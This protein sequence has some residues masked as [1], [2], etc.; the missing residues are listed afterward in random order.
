MEEQLRGFWIHTQK[1]CALFSLSPQLRGHTKLPERLEDEVILNIQ[2]ERK[3]ID[4]G[5][6]FCH[7]CSVA[8]S[9]PTLCDPQTA[10]CQA[11]LSFTI[12]WS[13]LRLLK[14]MS[15]ELMMASNHLILCHHLLL[16]P[17]IF[18]RIRVFFNEL[19]LCIRW[20][21]YWSFGFSISPS[22]EYSGLISFRINWFDLLAVQGT[23]KRLLQQHSLKPSILWHSAFF[24]VP[25][26]DTT[27]ATQQQQ[28]QGYPKTLTPRT[29]GVTL[30]H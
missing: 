26:K 28:Q 8:Q 17:S 11:S 21:N 27:E 22:S 4:F 3:N 9:C 12:S 23:L 16:L 1:W 25:T 2:E 30:L 18:P 19:A 20:A 5:E 7:T 10:A 14:L 6:Q 15:I 24:M 29:K 13:L